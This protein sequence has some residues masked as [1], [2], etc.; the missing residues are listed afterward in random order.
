MRLRLKTP[1]LSSLLFFLSLFSLLVVCSAQELKFHEELELAKKKYKIRGREYCLECIDNSKCLECHENID[2]TKFAKS[3]HG[4]NSCN[5]CHWDIT[6]IEVHTE[7]GGRIHVEPVTCHRCHKVEGAEH[8]ASA[9]FINDV[10][11]ADCH[12]KIHEITPWGGNKARVI[13]TCTICHE[14]DGYSES[15]HGEVAL[16]GNKDSAN[17]SD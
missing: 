11:C 2:V 6:D 14:D 5:S 9:H 7:E 13:T 4:A 10:R 8:Y 3:V 16:A 12:V 15:I 17:C 1:F